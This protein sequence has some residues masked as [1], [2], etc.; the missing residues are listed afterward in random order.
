MLIA[1]MKERDATIKKRSMWNID[2]DKTEAYINH[3]AIDHLKNYKKL[4]D[5]LQKPKPILK[6]P[7]YGKQAKPLD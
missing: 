2:V 7:K 6:N 4:A 3:M 5:D 1:T